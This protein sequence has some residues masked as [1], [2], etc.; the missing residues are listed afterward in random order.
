MQRE[1]EILTIDGYDNLVFST[2]PNALLFRGRLMLES[3]V[4]NTTLESVLWRVQPTPCLRG[5]RYLDRSTPLSPSQVVMHGE[6][7]LGWLLYATQPPASPTRIEIRAAMEMVLTDLASLPTSWAR[8][9]S[10][11][12]EDGSGESLE[13]KN[14]LFK[15]RPASHL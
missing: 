8:G 13:Q 6:L 9:S 15:I 1:E 3:S 5:R 10:W 12:E 7:T 2:G 11:S 14:L 4:L